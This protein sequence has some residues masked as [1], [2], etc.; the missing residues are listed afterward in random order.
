MRDKARDWAIVR[1]ILEQN[2]QE[3]ERME[4]IKGMEGIKGMEA[5]KGVKEIKGMKAMKMK[6]KIKASDGAEACPIASIAKNHRRF[7]AKIPAM[8]GAAA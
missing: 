4:A 1:D 3:R 5:M 2:A 6:S 7:S 8:K